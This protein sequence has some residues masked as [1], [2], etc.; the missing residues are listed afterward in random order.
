MSEA[1]PVQNGLKQ[2]HALSTLLFNTA[3]EYA[4]RKVHENQKGS[5]LH[6]T[7]QLLICA[8]DVNVFGEN[9]NT[10]KKDA[11]HMLEA[12]R[13]VGL[14]ENTEKTQYMIM[15]HHENE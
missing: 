12:S 8:D 4:I 1:L 15:S 2:G 14:E 7:D 10:I 3:L 5:E 11:E 13:E 9:T 6:G